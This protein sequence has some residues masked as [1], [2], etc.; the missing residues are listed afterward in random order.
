MPDVGARGTYTFHEANNA[1]AIRKMPLAGADSMPVDSKTN[2]S[3][4]I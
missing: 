4:E 2:Q 1:M 3:W